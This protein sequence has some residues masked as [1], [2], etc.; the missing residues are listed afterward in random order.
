[1]KWVGSDLNLCGSAGTANGAEA[2]IHRTG[3]GFEQELARSE[4][5]KVGSTHSHPLPDM[6]VRGPRLEAHWDREEVSCAFGESREVAGST[7]SPGF[8]CPDVEQS[9]VPFRS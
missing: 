9:V 7:M 5:S 4:M 3:P 6:L 2:Y 1:M 8:F